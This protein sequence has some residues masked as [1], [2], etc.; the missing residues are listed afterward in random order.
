MKQEKRTQYS[1]HYAL[2]GRGRKESLQFEVKGDR[3]ELV[4]TRA[5]L[6]M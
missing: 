4:P 2:K 6:G 1:R 3:T 5:S